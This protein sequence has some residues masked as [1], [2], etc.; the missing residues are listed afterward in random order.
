LPPARATQ[1]LLFAGPQ[2]SFIGS[3][4]QRVGTTTTNIDD[5]VRRQDI[6]IVA[7]AGFERAVSSGA[8]LVDVR[9]VFGVRDLAA[10]GAN[11]QKSRAMQILMGYRF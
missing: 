6:G 10:V 3:V 8:M 2:L 5:F 1:W 4:D 9:A 7:G 11:S